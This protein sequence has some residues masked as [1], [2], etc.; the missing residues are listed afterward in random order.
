MGFGRLILFAKTIKFL[1]PKQVYYRLYYIIK[2]R[3]SRKTY[4]VIK[5]KINTTFLNT[6]VYENLGVKYFKKS[7]TFL[8]K[9]KIFPEDIDWNFLGYGKLWNYNLNYFDFLNNSGLSKEVGLYLIKNHI[10]MHK[11]L[12]EGL[13]SYPISLRSINWIKF[14]S[15]YKIQDSEINKILL[16]DYYRLMDNLEYD[17]MGNHLLEN[18]FSILFG[19][20]YF[21][22]EIFYKRAIKIIKL[23]LEEQILSDGCHF[24]LS[25]MYHQIILY[26]LMDCVYLVKNNLWKKEEEFLMFLEKKAEKMLSFLQTI[27]YNDGNI[28]MFNDSAY[29]IAPSSSYLFQFAKQL[30][31]NYTIIKL[32]ESGYRKVKADNYELFIDL[33]KVGPSYQ[34]GHAHADMLSFELKV[35]NNPFIVD[36]G[37]STYEINDLRQEER[38][39][40]S[41]NTVTVL[42]KNQSEVWGGFRVGKRAKICYLSEVNNTLTAAH[43]GFKKLVGNHER[44]FRYTKNKIVI[45]D[46]LLK[47]NKIQATA[48]FHFDSSIKLI[49]VSENKISC[50]NGTEISYTSF[51]HPIK[52]ITK[53]YKLAKGFNNTINALMVR[54]TFNHQLTTEIKL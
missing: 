19:S 24:E 23:Q 17:L 7:F 10:S 8:N 12:K 13:Q 42:N 43:N 53:N 39:T 26:R 11:L 22:N 49:R 51:N 46:S 25:P 47:K 16:S 44:E 38:S 30:G 37:V 15:K 9:T 48:V 28:P 34:A 45:K 41:H 54:V 31:L 2:T 5:N 6:Y 18:G 32:T 27:T 21:K 36:R 14:V 20:Y 4:K 52:V 33:G 3:L 50:S 29:G 40:K 1:K 35:N